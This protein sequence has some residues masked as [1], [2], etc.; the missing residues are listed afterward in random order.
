MEENASRVSLAKR[1]LTTQYLSNSRSTTS[2]PDL[3]QPSKKQQQQAEDL[4]MRRGNS[5]LLASSKPTRDQLH[6]PTINKRRHSFSSFLNVKYGKLAAADK[7]RNV[8]RL[9]TLSLTADVPHV[10]TEKGIQ[11]VTQG[12]RPR[13]YSEIPYNIPHVERAPPVAITNKTPAYEYYGFVMYLTSFVAFGLYLIWAYVPDPILHSLGITY[14]PDRYW[15][16][17]IPVWLMTVVW[18]IFTSFMAIN[19][20]NTAPFDSYHCITDE[21]AN[22]MCLEN[23]RMVDQPSDWIPELHDI[24]IGLSTSSSSLSSINNPPNVHTPPPRKADPT[25][26]K[27]L[28]WFPHSDF[29]EQ[30]ECFRNG[31]RL[32]LETNR[33]IIAPMLRI[34]NIYP[35]MPFE[36]LARRYEAQDKKILHDLCSNNQRHWRT[37]LEPCETINEWT[38]IP[39]SSVMDLEAIKR[40]FG[41]RIIE[42]TQG[43]GWGVHE[44]A[45]GGNIHPEDVAIVDVMSFKENGTDWEHVDPAM[46]ALKQKAAKNQGVYSWIQSRFFSQKAKEQDKLTEPLK[47]VFSEEQLHALDVKIIQFGALSSAARYTTP[48]TDIQMTLRKSMMKTHFNVPDQMKALSDQANKIVN[49]LG[50]RFEY[51]TLILNLAKL[52]AL[53]ARAGT[54]QSLDVDGKK[55]TDI[56]VDGPKSMD[57]LDKQAKKDLMDALVLEIFGDIPI[58]QAVSAAMPIKPSKL[59]EFLDGS[60]FPVTEAN[61][62]YKLLEACVDYHKNVEKRYPIYYLISEMDIAPESRPDIFGPLLDMFPCVFSKQDMLNWGIQTENWSKKQPGLSDTVNYEKLFQPLLNILIAGKG[63][64]FF[65]IPTTPLTRF[66]N[67]SPKAK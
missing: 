62:R 6:K 39:W 23:Q 48:P 47:Y 21:H 38:E 10:S 53:D 66:L 8:K 9:A 59:S 1:L 25:E 41:V 52:V 28:S 19:L 33:T 40:D 13:S 46:E 31:I 45:L 63:Y 67:W 44:S 2:L 5:Q 30:Q 12:H 56:E 43:H 29:P 64:S 20:M 42:R 58:N 60:P 18:F 37:E 11:K 15:A 50:G 36:D 51:S 7:M 54:I 17:A 57:D 65:E 49:A 24:S 32:A 55:E 27:Y 4:F 61:Q 26:E 22:I 16:L 3:I 35:W 34:N 14:Y